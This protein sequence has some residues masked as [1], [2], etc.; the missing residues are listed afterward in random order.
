MVETK[1]IERVVDKWAGK[2]AAATDEYR[3]GVE[4]PRADW[5][6]ETLKAQDRY[7]TG[8]IQ[9]AQ[10]GRFGRGVQRAGTDK[11][12]KGATTKG[13]DRWTSG[14]QA[15]KDD[16]RNR[17]QEVLS[18]IQSVSLSPR[19]PKGSPQNYKRVQEVGDALHKKFK[20]R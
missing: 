3:Q 12:K 2:V 15:A 13:P 16:Y 20:G 4:N 8:V 1:P 7:R 14:V 9:A 19:G 11:W 17:M 6:S 10:E 18:T 5:A